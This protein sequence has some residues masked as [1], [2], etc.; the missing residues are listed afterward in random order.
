MAIES[1]L[2]DAKGKL[3]QNVT[4]TTF[5][6]NE[7][8][9]T[10]GLDSSAT[11]HFSGIL[12]HYSPSR[13]PNTLSP[14]GNIAVLNLQ[15]LDTS[16]SL[17]ARFPTTNL[18]LILAYR[19]S[20]TTLQ[21]VSKRLGI[22]I[23]G[24]S[25]ELGDT[26]GAY[27]DAVTLNATASP[28]N[29]PSALDKAYESLQTAHN[30]APD[31]IPYLH[32]NLRVETGSDRSGSSSNGNVTTVATA[33]VLSCAAALA[34]ALTIWYCCRMRRKRRAI[35]AERRERRDQGIESLSTVL[36]FLDVKPLPIDQ[37]TYLRKI[38]LNRGNFHALGLQN[39]LATIQTMRSC[40]MPTE[41]GPGMGADYA[42]DSMDDPTLPCHPD[43]KEQVPM[44]RS[45]KAASRLSKDLRQLDNMATNYPA[46]A[47]SDRSNRPRSPNLLTSHVPALLTHITDSIRSI[48]STTSALG[49]DQDSPSC[50]ICLDTFNLHTYI[51]QL[52]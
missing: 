3:S 1:Y 16:S 11:L 31:L 33:S 24:I 46:K 26:L 2:F 52:P 29:L 6:V 45:S 32:G 14:Y 7:T 13:A 39:A 20:P 27:L 8:C 34:I 17:M 23:V 44:L 22:G 4:S 48:R 35:M 50:T 21:E 49:F 41:L 5:F 40:N 36:V 9:V 19:T 10:A 51:R 43:S 30:D 25:N 18:Q 47:A 28:D 38:K 37:L 15:T 12:F 42:T